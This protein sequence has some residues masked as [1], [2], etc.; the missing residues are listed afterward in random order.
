M[1]IHVDLRTQPG[2][3]QIRETEDFRSFKV[4]VCGQGGREDLSAALAPLGFLTADDAY[5]KIAAVRALA[6]EI[7]RDPQWSASFE[8]MVEYADAHGWVKGNHL[9]AH[10]EFVN[11]SSE[12]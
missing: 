2:S 10:C 4:I 8:A 3:I 5:L 7:A 12:R 6:G 11:E 9:Q 1:Y